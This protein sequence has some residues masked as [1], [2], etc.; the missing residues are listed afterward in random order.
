M[1]IRDDTL[2]IKWQYN[3]T[4]QYPSCT[5]HSVQRAECCRMNCRT[6]CHVCSSLSSSYFQSA[7]VCAHLT[8]CLFTAPQTVPLYKCCIRNLGLYQ[9]IWIA[10]RSAELEHV[11]RSPLLVS[12]TLQRLPAASAIIISLSTSNSEITSSNKTALVGWGNAHSLGQKRVVR[13][14]RICQ[15]CGRAHTKDR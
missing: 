10:H 14:F 3:R 4:L 1:G 12:S 13:G 11:S 7:V 2:A 15:L 8:T 9:K 5:K 6:V